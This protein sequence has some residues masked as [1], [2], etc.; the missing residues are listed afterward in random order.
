[1]DTQDFNYINLSYLKNMV[2]GDAEMMQTML[3]MLVEE[4]PDEMTKMVDSLTVENWEDIFQ[5]SHKMKTTLGFVGNEDMTN[6]NKS[7]EHAARHRVNLEEIP[8]MVIKLK[9]L[10]HHVVAELAQAKG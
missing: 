8:T 6:I 10:S 5:V 9:E 4:I 7:L 1:M 3:D 2:G